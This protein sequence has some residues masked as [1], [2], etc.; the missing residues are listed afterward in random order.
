MSDFAERTRTVFVVVDPAQDRPLALERILNLARGQSNSDRD[1]AEKGGRLHVFVAVDCDNTDTNA[2]NPA[3]HRNGRWFLE[4]IVEPLEASGLRF[5]L[6]MS[7]SSDWYGAII[8]RS[9]ELKASLIMLPLLSNPSEAARLFNESIWRLMRTAECPVIV[10]RPAAQTERSIILAAINLQSHKPEYQRLND[11]IITS[12][13]WIARTYGS[14][15]HF[16]NAY[17]DSLNYPD[18]TQLATRTGVD[19]AHIHVL[20]GDADDVIAKT[21][22]EIGAT[23]VVIGTRNR[24]SRWRGNTAERIITKVECD[25]LAIN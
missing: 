13:Q 17:S 6:E 12:S 3:M 2:N 15:L 16:V 22:K 8:Q 7:W 11:V 18:R 10:V 23:V 14:E 1:E 9:K 21:A 19:T 25:I 24:S 4:N 20:S 5:H